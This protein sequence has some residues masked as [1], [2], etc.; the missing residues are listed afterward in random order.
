MST[1]NENRAEEMGATGGATG[2]TGIHCETETEKAGQG[3]NIKDRVSESAQQMKQQAGQKVREYGDRA[4]QYAD[5]ARQQ[6][7]REQDHSE[8][9]VAWMIE[10]QTARLPSDVFLWTAGG[11]I[12]L[13]LALKM[14]GRD[15]DALFVGQW[16]P[17]FLI[18]GLY[19][20]IVKVHGHDEND[21]APADLSSYSSYDAPYGESSY[22]GSSSGGYGGSDYGYED[23]R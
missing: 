5:R 9:R 18:L 12:A 14:N 20:K 2:A 1:F 13:S 6:M 21:Y 22:A 3:P 8:G 4:R 19:N 16:A 23:L 11:C 10:N 7:Y 15:T 17:T